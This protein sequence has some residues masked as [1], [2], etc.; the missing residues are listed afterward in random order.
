M[1]SNA[2]IIMNKSWRDEGS[3]D[4]VSLESII[5]AIAL[6]GL[7]KMM[8]SLSQGTTAPD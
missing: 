6:E 3:S 2:R 5:P 7:R 8:N 1:H 4:H